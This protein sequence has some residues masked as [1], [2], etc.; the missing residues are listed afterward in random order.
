MAAKE[1]MGW[2]PSTKRWRQRYKGKLRQFV[3]LL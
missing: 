1:L 2:V 3:D